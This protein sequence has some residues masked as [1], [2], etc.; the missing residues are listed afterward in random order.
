MLHFYIKVELTGK[1]IVRI[2]ELTN[3]EFVVLLKTI[4]EDD[5]EDVN[6]VV[7]T[8]IKRVLKTPSDFSTLTYIDKVILLLVLRIV[9]I[10]TDVVKQDP[11]SHEEFNLPLLDVVNEILEKTEGLHSSYSIEMEGMKI[12]ISLPKALRYHDA[13]DEI[14]DSLD[15]VS[16]GEVTVPYRDLSPEEK[17]SIENS[18]GQAQY[19]R[20]YQQIREFDANV[21]GNI[22]LLTLANFFE[23]KEFTLSYFSGE[24]SSFVLGIFNHDYGEFMKRQFEFI[25]KI[26][27]SY[28]H[29]Q[30]ITMSDVQA[31]VA[32]YNESVA[33]AQ[34][35]QKE[36][37]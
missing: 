22:K 16:I 26:G 1:K 36:K 27:S 29:F 31:F 30:A 32:K 10:G 8:I 35:A 6:D 12:G 24:M 33:E 34:E 3:Q 37:P 2:R 21:L 19:Q 25:N 20:V 9:S 4:M 18:M 17:G 11:L 28:E 23:T 13:M 15:F 14:S 7:D 5:G